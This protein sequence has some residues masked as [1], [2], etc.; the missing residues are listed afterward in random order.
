MKGSGNS[1]WAAGLVCL[2]TLAIAEEAMITEQE[3]LDAAGRALRAERARGEPLF[4][5]WPLLSAAAPKLVQDVTGAPSYWIV[6]LVSGDRFVGFV[7][8]MPDGGIAAIGVTCDR[9]QRPETCPTPTF[10]LSRAELE[11]FARASGSLT[12]D[13]Q[14]S[15]PRLVHDG[16]PGRDMWLIETRKDGSPDRWIFVGAGGVYERPAGAVHGADPALE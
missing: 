14:A 11:N 4:S 10:A 1:V 15:A 9:P 13:D 5:Q 6:G 8:V 2:A 16:P 3:A 7:R 12:D